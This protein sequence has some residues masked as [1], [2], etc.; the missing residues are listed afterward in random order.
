MAKHTF[1]TPGFPF[2]GTE[3]VDI[4]TRSDVKKIVT[5]G[6]ELEVSDNE[7]K[8]KAQERKLTKISEQ[9]AAALK[10]A[11]EAREEV[12]R[13]VETARE[14]FCEVIEELLTPHYRLLAQ[15]LGIKVP[16]EKAKGKIKVEK[17]SVSKNF[18]K[19]A[20]SAKKAPPSK[21]KTTALKKTTASR[22]GRKGSK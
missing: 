22:S 21:K 12:N 7:K 1:V 13:I 11:A 18:K 19:K 16:E 17:N 20:P 4:L 5:E 9:A 3:K 6:I 15:H 10:C 14:T 8:L 2:N